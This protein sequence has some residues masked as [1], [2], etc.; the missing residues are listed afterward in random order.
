MIA[1]LR[2]T[3][4]INVNRQRNIPRRCAAVKYQVVVSHPSFPVDEKLNPMGQQHRGRISVRTRGA[5]DNT[6]ILFKGYTERRTG[7]KEDRNVSCRYFAF[8]FS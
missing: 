4:V 1:S 5:S 8:E 7:V 3:S 6:D 2:V